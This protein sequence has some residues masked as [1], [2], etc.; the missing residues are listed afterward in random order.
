[1]KRV[2]ACIALISAVAVVAVIVGSAAHGS[3]DSGYRITMTPRSPLT[4]AAC[5]S[6]L[7]AKGSGF[8]RQQCLAGHGKPWFVIHI[9]NVGDERGYPACHA[10]AFDAGATALFEDDLPLGIIGFP[11]GPSV[12]KG[13]AFRLA[14]YMPVADPHTYIKRSDWTP[15]AIDRYSVSCHG[16]SESQIPI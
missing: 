5:V 11:A 15:A 6:E 1:M 2:L 16:R 14:W 12:Q 3:G 13:T 8:G 10:T 7:K 4:M 9:R